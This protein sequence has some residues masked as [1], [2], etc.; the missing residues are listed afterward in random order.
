MIV[1]VCA[2][3]NKNVYFVHDTD[4]LYSSSREIHRSQQHPKTLNKKACNKLTF[5]PVLKS[6]W[7]RNDL[8]SLLL[9]LLFCLLLTSRQ[10][11]C[12]VVCP[13]GGNYTCICIIVCGVNLFYLYHS[14]WNLVTWF[15]HFNKFHSRVFVHSYTVIVISNSRSI[16]SDLTSSLPHSNLPGWFQAANPQG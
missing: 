11:C 9:K 1:H 2:C 4:R 15:C 14:C 12:A 3:K 8:L 6:W 10:R 5:S 7:R 13:K 16:S